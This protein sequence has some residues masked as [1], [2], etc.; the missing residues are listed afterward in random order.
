M[1]TT[2][3]SPYHYI[4]IGWKIESYSPNIPDEVFYSGWHSNPVEFVS[5]VHCVT[6]YPCVTDDEGEDFKIVHI[7]MD[8]SFESIDKA[9]EWA[10]STSTD[11]ES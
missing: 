3:K 8:T 6:C 2:S 7:N 4:L 5:C 10:R 9:A 11:S 1:N